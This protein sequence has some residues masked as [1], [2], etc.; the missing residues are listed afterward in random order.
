VPKFP[1]V[2]DS[3][4]TYC[5]RTLKKYRCNFKMNIYCNF[6][7]NRNVATSFNSGDIRLGDRLNAN[8]LVKIIYKN[9]IKV[10]IFPYE[11]LKLVN[12]YEP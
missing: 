5:M 12:N 8:F 6:N 3:E 7:C 9:K 4:T 10:N 11:I 1:L 2:I